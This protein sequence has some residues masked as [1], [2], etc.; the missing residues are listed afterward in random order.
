MGATFEIV[1][2]AVTE[3]TE[4]EKEVVELDVGVEQKHRSEPEFRS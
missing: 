1:A 2:L 3:Q 4:T